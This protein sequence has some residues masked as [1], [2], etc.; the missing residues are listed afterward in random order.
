MYPFTHNLPKTKQTATLMPHPAYLWLQIFSTY[1]PKFSPEFLPNQKY[2]SFL[3]I[4][5]TT[6]Y[7]ALTT[8][9]MLVLLLPLAHPLAYQCTKHH[10][11]ILKIKVIN[12]RKR[13]WDITSRFTF[14]RLAYMY[15][16]TS[17][18]VL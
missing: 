9:Q 4:Q 11:K 17:A 1:F 18:F 6:L 2:H 16:G 10:L 13:K 5:L 15:C 3:S 8:L 7:Q 12:D 14:S